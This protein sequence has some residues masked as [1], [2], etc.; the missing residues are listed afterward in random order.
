MC[1]FF[2]LYAAVHVIASVLCTKPGK[3]KGSLAGT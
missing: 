3:L 2:P 1:S